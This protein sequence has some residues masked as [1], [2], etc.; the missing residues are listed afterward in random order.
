MLKNLAVSLGVTPDFYPSSALQIME[1]GMAIPVQ[2]AV[3][4]EEKS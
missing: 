4:N 2:A 3:E 1:H